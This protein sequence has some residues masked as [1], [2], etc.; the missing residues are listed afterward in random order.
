MFVRKY[1]AAFVLFSLMLGASSVPAAAG[2]Y[3]S[4]A[5][6][7]WKDDNGKLH[8]NSGAS[9]NAPSPDRADEA[10]LDACS[11]DGRNCK[12]V[13]TFARGGCGFISVGMNPNATRYGTGATPQR[14]FEN[15]VK[16]GFEC[17]PAKGGCTTKYND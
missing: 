11:Q 8:V 14:A 15:C 12:I 10:A 9:W 5:A 3:G 6:G 13:K 17:R 2:A 1:A 16:D 7:F 4:L